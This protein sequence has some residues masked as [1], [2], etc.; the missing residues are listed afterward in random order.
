MKAGKYIKPVIYA[1]IM[2]LLSACATSTDTAP[3]AYLFTYIR[4]P[5]T[6]DL[7]NTPANFTK[8]I[9]ETIPLVPDNHDRSPARNNPVLAEN[10]AAKT[11]KESQEQTGKVVKIT[12]PF[13]GYG[14]YTELNS[15]AIV[16]IAKQHGMTEVYFADMEILDILGILR[17]NKLY[18][19]GR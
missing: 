11:E 9:V 6:I 10:E 14:L 13:S 4:T 2:S 7:N 15:N 3:Q 8:T 16:D 1:A 5:Y 18:I 19:Y 17:H 12:E